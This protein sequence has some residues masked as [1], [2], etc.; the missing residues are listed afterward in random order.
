MVDNLTFKKLLRDWQR[1]DKGQTPI[2]HPGIL[3]IAGD[4]FLHR[5][6]A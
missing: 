4:P 5:I 2:I 3:R 6:I 1:L